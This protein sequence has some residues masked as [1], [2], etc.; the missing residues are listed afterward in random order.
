MLQNTA[1]AYNLEM[2]LFPELHRKILKLVK[3]LDQSD[4]LFVSYGLRT[5]IFYISLMLKNNSFL[6]ITQKR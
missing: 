5:F 6:A 1:E 2:P 3:E 4:L